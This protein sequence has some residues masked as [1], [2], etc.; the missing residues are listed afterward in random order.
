MKI[1]S[2]LFILISILIFSSGCIFF[3]DRGV[4]SNYYNECGH[5]YN[6][7]GIYYNDC[8]KNIVDYDELQNRFVK[9][10]RDNGYIVEF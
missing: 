8:D 7:Q 6:A 1:F 10:N 3:N 5:Y 9:Q 4:A 2:H